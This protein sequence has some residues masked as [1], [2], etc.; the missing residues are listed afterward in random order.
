MSRVKA[1][2]MTNSCIKYHRKNGY[3]SYRTSLTVPTP[4]FRMHKLHKLP[5]STLRLQTH[6]KSILTHFL[7]SRLPFEFCWW[8]YVIWLCNIYKKNFFGSIE[9]SF[10]K[11]K[12]CQERRLA[13]FVIF[14]DA[15]RVGQKFLTDVELIFVYL[16]CYSVF[17]V[18]FNL[19][20]G[21]RRQNRHKFVTEKCKN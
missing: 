11:K 12:I 8:E 3:S 10:T 1:V 18:S 13:K 20:R 16:Q 7:Y 9:Y 15:C 5:L 14:T 4:F 2:H 17:S 19:T 21:F 6:D